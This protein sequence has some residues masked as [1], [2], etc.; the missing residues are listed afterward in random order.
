MLPKSQ[1]NSNGRFMGFAFIG[2]AVTVIV[3]NICEHWSSHV[4]YVWPTRGSPMVITVLSEWPER[5]I[6]TGSPIMMDVW[7]HWMTLFDA[8]VCCFWTVLVVVWAVEVTWLSS[9]W[10]SSLRMNVVWVA[11]TYIRK[12][13]R[14]QNLT[15]FNDTNCHLHSPWCCSPSIDIWQIAVASVAP[16]CNGSGNGTLRPS[17]RCI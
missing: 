4:G 6:C 17:N 5:W 9:L 10:L 14:R 13:S 11:C 8:M 1:L 15:Q 12:H 3:P 2:M 16:F 7:A